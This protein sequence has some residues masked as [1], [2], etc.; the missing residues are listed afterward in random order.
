MDKNTEALLA[1]VEALCKAYVG[2]NA[3]SE[4]WGETCKRFARLD[5]LAKKVRK[6]ATTKN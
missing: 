4:M 6:A 2:K 1:E 3:E 5:K